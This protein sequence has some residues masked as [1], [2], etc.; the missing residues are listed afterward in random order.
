MAQL[1][2][3]RDYARLTR[4]E[5]AGMPVAGTGA[6]TASPL[7]APTPSG[8][9][10]GSRIDYVASD[11]AIDA[12]T[13]KPRQSKPVPTR[14]N[15]AKKSSANAASKVSDKAE[16]AA[17]RKAAAPFAKSFGAT[18]AAAATTE[19]LMDRHKA[20]LLG[21]LG[22]VRLESGGATV[23]G[24]GFGPKGFALESMVMRTLGPAAGLAVAVGA[25]I[26]L[27]TKASD[28][29]N[30]IFYEAA[31]RGVTVGTVL[32]ERADEFFTDTADVVR[33]AWGF[34]INKVL[35]LWGAQ[36][37]LAANALGWFGVGAE[38]GT[39]G[40]GRKTGELFDYVQSG[41][42]DWVS[43]LKGE[44]SS[45]E[46]QQAALRTVDANLKVR[47][48]IIVRNAKAQAEE[49][50]GV[51]QGL[52]FTGTRKS[53]EKAAAR[54]GIADAANEELAD[55]AREAA[56]QKEAVITSGKQG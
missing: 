4:G 2:A 19:S 32:R 37:Q 30:Q 27:G 35:G 17:S 28:A 6:A 26:Y 39:R 40:A 55:A 21:E 52:G 44:P 29:G 20:N 50:A 13:N 53:L 23:G 7:I 49:A 9:I 34:S 43:E 11:I 33:D 56:K 15:Q 3:L 18:S 24:Y 10:P 12:G 54:A 36:A 46:R 38:L 25:G 47:Q 1:K 31:E 8:E 42:S 14:S 5:L 48:N 41:V 16:R 51:L 45:G 22:Q